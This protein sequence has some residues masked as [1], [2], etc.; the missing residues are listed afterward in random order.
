VS[1]ETALPPS[2]LSGVDKEAIAKAAPRVQSA[3]RWFWWIAGLS[4]I[5]SVVLLTGGTFNFVLGLAV[6]Q[7]ADGAFHNLKIIALVFDALVV[8]FFF[9]AGFFAKKGHLWAF[10]VGGIAYLGDGIVFALFSEWVAVAFHAYALFMIYHGWNVLR[11]ELQSAREAP[12][13]VS[14]RPA[15]AAV[16]PPPLEAAT[17]P[18]IAPTPPPEA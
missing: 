8:G 12:P 9:G 1:P 7:L 11:T 18:P 5:N 14:P 15:L 4:V 6:T 10:V 3:A 2:P 16:T 13:L 17:P